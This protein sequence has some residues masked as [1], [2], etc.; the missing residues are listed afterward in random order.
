MRRNK[1]QGRITNFCWPSLRNIEI[2]RVEIKSRTNLEESAQTVCKSSL[3]KS[4]FL[5]CPLF[6]LPLFLF[7]I[8]AEYNILALPVEYSLFLYIFSFV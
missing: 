2:Q 5:N 7:S 3:Q 4:I 1:S 8:F 6:S